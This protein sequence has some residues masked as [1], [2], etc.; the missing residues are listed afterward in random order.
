LKITTV[1]ITREEHVT[2]GMGQGTSGS[3]MLGGGSSND[4]RGESQDGEE[5]TDHGAKHD[6]GW[7]EQRFKKLY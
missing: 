5:E 4:Q 3:K 7:L 2:C 6:G 1:E